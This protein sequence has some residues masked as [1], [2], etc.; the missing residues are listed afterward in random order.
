MGIESRGYYTALAT[1]RQAGRRKHRLNAIPV[2]GRS[3]H[4]EAGT[5]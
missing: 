4:F 1:L 2:P 3:H 5:G